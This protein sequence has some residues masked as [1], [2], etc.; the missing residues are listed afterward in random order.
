MTGIGPACIPDT[1]AEIAR[2]SANRH[3]RP[4]RQHVCSY[5]VVLRSARQLQ[6]REPPGIRSAIDKQDRRARDR[7]L[8]SGSLR[9]GCAMCS[10]AGSALGRHPGRSRE[11]SFADWMPDFMDDGLFESHSMRAVTVS[12]AAMPG[13][14]HRRGRL[15]RRCC[16]LLLQTGIIAGRW[17]YGRRRGAGRREAHPTAKRHQGCGY[18]VTSF[19]S[20]HFRL[21]FIA[22]IRS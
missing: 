3:H 11:I 22:Q 2:V 1:T 16:V 18:R 17:R 6:Y 10:F 9:S 5:P 7:C 20:V 14:L 19:H 15:S 4:F 13:N 8:H 21:L 12:P